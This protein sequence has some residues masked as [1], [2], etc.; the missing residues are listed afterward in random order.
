MQE[1]ETY[2]WVVTGIFLWGRLGIF[3]ETGVWLWDL[4][5]AEQEANSVG[6][7]LVGELTLKIHGLGVTDST[8]M[9]SGPQN[10]LYYIYL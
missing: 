8:G 1:T 2:E 9:A 6:R 10:T 4:Y 3:G 7:N 5:H